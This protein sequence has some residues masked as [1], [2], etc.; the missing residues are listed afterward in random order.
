[1]E[2]TTQLLSHTGSQTSSFP[3]EVFDSLPASEA[4]SESTL[5]GANGTEEVPLSFACQDCRLYG[6]LHRPR[7]RGRSGVLIV[8]GGPQ[9]RVGSHRQFVL[10]A[11]FLA[12][13]SI[14][15]LRFDY[16]GMGDSEGEQQLIMVLGLLKFTQQEEA[17]FLLDEPDT[18]L[19]PAWSIEYLDLLREVVGDGRQSHFIITTHDPLVIAGLIK[20]QVQILERDEEYMIR[21]VQP[22]DDPRGMGIAALLTSEI[23]GLRSQF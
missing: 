22:L 1:M 19:N 9:Y 21:A 7:S 16:R 11:R 5:S 10:L 13:R 18:H 23:Y 4:A 17:L 6:V 8:V 3:Q 12:G 20:E 14:P 2:A 15:V